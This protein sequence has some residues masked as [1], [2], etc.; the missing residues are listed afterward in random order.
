VRRHPTQAEGDKNVGVQSVPVVM[1]GRY[2]NPWNTDAAM[3]SFKEI[4]KVRPCSSPFTPPPRFL[5]SP[6][7]Q[8]IVY[9]I[10]SHHAS[11]VHYSS[12]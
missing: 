8:D 1:N 2:Y 11:L 10:P 7:K 4:F 9:P 12:Y 6:A 5:A 3:K